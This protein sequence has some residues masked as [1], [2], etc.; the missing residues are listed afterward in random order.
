MRKVTVI[1]EVAVAG[2]LAAHVEHVLDA[3]DLL[4]ERRRHG[5][6]YR[7]ARKPPD[8]RRDLHSRRDDLRVLR[9]RQ[10]CERAKPGGSR[11]ENA[12]HGRKDEG[13]R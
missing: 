10:D 2:R 6:R 13:D 8:T 11:Q 1:V 5:A 9:N 12:Q 4:F 3:V 7:V